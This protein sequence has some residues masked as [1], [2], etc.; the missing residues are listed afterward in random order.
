MER[1][2]LLEVSVS[3]F[4]IAAFALIALGLAACNTVGGIG[5]DVQSVGRTMEDAAD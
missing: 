3:K 5:K 1:E 4:R 2:I